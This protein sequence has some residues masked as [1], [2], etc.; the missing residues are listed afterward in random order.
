MTSPEQL[1]V[2]GEAADP[3]RVVLGI[4]T[5]VAGVDV[6]PDESFFDIG[7]DSIQLMQVCGRINEEYGEVIDLFLLFENPTVDECVA[8]IAADAGR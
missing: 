6:R 7:L 2:P 3:H 1:P 8:L 4:V 5:E